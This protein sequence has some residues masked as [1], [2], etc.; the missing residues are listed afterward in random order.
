MYHK[1]DYPSIR[2]ENLPTV[3][4]TS[5][6]LPSPSWQEFKVYIDWFPPFIEKE[7]VSLSPLLFFPLSKTFLPSSLFRIFSVFSVPNR[8]RRVVRTG[9]VFVLVF[10][11]RGWEREK[12]G[13]I[14]TMRGL[15]G[16]WTR[17]RKKE[18]YGEEGR[19]G[20]GKEET[21]YISLF[22][23]PFQKLSLHTV[24]YHNSLIQNYQSHY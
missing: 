7:P 6:F 2:T 11:E 1:T 21:D 20:W 10:E 19:A 8:V 4:Y 3:L 18:K 14:M 9:R 17:K 23:K 13:G 24:H 5:L 15:E 16:R 12:V 22:I